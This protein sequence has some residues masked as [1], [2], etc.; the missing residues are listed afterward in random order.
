MRKLLI[1]TVIVLAFG[2]V[3]LVACTSGAPISPG[4][5]SQSVGG[6]A[7][8]SVHMSDTNF[9][10]NAVT[11]SKG[12]SLTLVDD[13]DSVHI[14]QNGTWDNGIVEAGIEPGA[15]RVDQTFAGNDT[16]QIGPFTTAGTFKLF[17]TVHPGMNLTVIVK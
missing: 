1:V 17:C 11:L 12:S 3:L 9:K 7:G 14:I 13:T 16:H 6:T 15:P 4:G 2:S 8:V 5:S 10:E